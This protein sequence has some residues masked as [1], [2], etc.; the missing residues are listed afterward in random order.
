MFGGHAF[1]R[2]L[3]FGV[4]QAPKNKPIFSCL[5]LCGGALGYISNARLQFLNPIFPTRNIVSAVWKHPNS[6]AASVSSASIALRYQ[7]N[8]VPAD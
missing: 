6:N 5:C 2:I 3:Y 7:R 4:K 1:S 8:N